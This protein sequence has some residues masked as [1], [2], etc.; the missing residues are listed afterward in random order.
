MNLL[1]PISFWQ[2]SG[3][4]GLL[5][6]IKCFEILDILFRDLVTSTEIVK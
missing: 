2:A 5:W 6:G 3:L 1:E 4:L